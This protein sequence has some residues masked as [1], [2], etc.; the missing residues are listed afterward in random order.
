MGEEERSSRMGTSE[1]SS[2]LK[3]TFGSESVPLQTKTAA[4]RHSQRGSLKRYCC[5]TATDDFLSQSNNIMSN[6]RFLL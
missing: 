2:T 1:L 5:G 3:S 4:L 6:C